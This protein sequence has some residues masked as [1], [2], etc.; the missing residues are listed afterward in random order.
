MHNERTYLKGHE[1]W[2]RKPRPTLYL[3]TTEVNK[4]LYI[5]FILQFTYK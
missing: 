5:V 3:R 2:F 4:V 1:I